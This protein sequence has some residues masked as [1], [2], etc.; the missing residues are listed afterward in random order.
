MRFSDEHQLDRCCVLLSDCVRRSSFTLA[1][2]LPPCA[3][4]NFQNPALQFRHT[5]A[6]HIPLPPHFN[7]YFADSA[8]VVPDERELQA[9]AAKRRPARPQFVRRNIRHPSFKNFSIH[10]A[11]TQLTEANTPIGAAMVRPH[12]KS[13]R[14]LVISMRLPAGQMW[15]VDVKELGQRSS[16]LTLA[17]PLEV[18]PIPSQKHVY[19]DLDELVARYIEPLGSAMRALAKHPKW[20][21][22]GDEAP[23]SWAQVQ[24][25][26]RAQRAASTGYV[27]YCL[28]AETEPGRIGA[29]Y[30][31]YLMGS[32]PRREFFVV[33]PEGFYFRKKVYPTIDDM[34]V[35]F[36][37]DPTNKAGRPQQPEAQYAAAAAPQAVAQYGAQPY[38]QQPQYGGQQ[39]AGWYGGGSQWG[40]TTAQ[41]PY[42][43][44]QYPQQYAPQY[45]GGATGWGR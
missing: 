19:D 12:A 37:R 32:T 16:N 43:Q 20:R 5:L 23:M 10:E 29:F 6:P 2:N 11:T 34:L 22:G 27:P 40:P 30:L 38:T 24:E 42:G 18:N 44:Q 25:N 35:A 13:L 21:G 36:K 9:E 45:G 39:Q 17:P 3:S 7:P 8:Y 26:L 14:T 28:A 15:H 41:D 4:P 31:A 1:P 33:L